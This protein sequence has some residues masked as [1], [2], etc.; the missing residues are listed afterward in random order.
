MHGLGKDYTRPDAMNE[1]LKVPL[2]DPRCFLGSL[3]YSAALQT[4]TRSP[5]IGGPGTE[6][7]L[8]I[9]AR[10]MGGNISRDCDL[11]CVF[12]RTEVN[13]KTIRPETYS[14]QSQEN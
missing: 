2:N 12:C 8:D 11:F 7:G 5:I 4:V 6:L 3:L 13:E 9:R 1:V 10:D 14:L